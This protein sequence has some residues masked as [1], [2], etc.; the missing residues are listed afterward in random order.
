MHAWLR[1]ISPSSYVKYRIDRFRCAMGYRPVSARRPVAAKC[2][3]SV[4]SAAPFPPHAT[5]TGKYY[6]YP[7]LLCEGETVRPGR[8]NLLH[9][10]AHEEHVRTVTDP[11]ITKAST[12]FNMEKKD[13]KILYSANCVK[14]TLGSH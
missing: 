10:R 7:S 3:L 14:R 1:L 2:H 6:A 8:P 13:N 11:G 9:V 4:R 5:I 12:K